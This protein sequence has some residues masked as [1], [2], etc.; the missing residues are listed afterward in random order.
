MTPEQQKAMRDAQMVLEALNQQRKG[1][2]EKLGER[3][4]TLLDS[5]KLNVE[6]LENADLVNAL[7]EIV[8]SV[9]SALLALSSHDKLIDLLIRDLTGTHSLASTMQ[10]GVIQASFAVEAIAGVL[11]E[12]GVVTQEDLIAQETKVKERIAEMREAAEKQASQPPIEI[13]KA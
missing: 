3:T 12:K 7:R 10:E 8:Q 4:Q 6:H 9:N 13:V 2:I 1:A 11:L 5:G